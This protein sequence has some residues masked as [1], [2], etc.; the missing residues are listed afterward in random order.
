M[1]KRG[2]RILGWIYI[3]LAV[4]LVLQIVGFVYLVRHS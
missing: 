4:L 2:L 3:A 1:T